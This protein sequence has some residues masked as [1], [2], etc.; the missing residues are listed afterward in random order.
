MQQ[1]Q[2]SGSGSSYRP[3]KA[4]RLRRAACHPGSSAAPSF[5]Q[6]DQN[7]A[8]DEY[9][10]SSRDLCSVLQAIPLLDVALLWAGLGEAEKRSM[11]QSN[12]ALRNIANLC[13]RSTNLVLSEPE[14]Q[15][16]VRQPSPPR[17]MVT[18]NVMRT[19]AA[20]HPPGPFAPP[21]APLVSPHMKQL[22]AFPSLTKLQI[23]W[24]SAASAP[25]SQLLSAQDLQ[26][27]WRRLKELKLNAPNET[28][29]AAAAPGADAQPLPAA[30]ARSPL[31]LPEGLH[32]LTSLC[33]EG[34]VEL[35]AGS[36]PRGPDQL[37][38]SALVLLELKSVNFQDRAA[39]SE[40]GAIR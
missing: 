28:A 19:H 10:L 13:I 20:L 16:P 36:L 32:H 5:I 29:P 17:R 24:T 9:L 33:M 7:H 1:Q 35:R 30:A 23:R 37:S 34:L 11:R 27:L 25:S 31:R 21:S 12:K 18:R 26:P 2:G 40:I 15:E 3:S 8:E 38:F 22:L 39:L 6:A 14:P 4:Q